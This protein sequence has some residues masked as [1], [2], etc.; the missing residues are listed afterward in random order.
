MK[1]TALITAL[2]FGVAILV[3]CTEKIAPT[4]LHG[5]FLRNDYK[6]ERSGQ[7]VAFENRAA[8]DAILGVAKTM[9]NAIDQPDFDK[10]IVA[11]IFAGPGERETTITV[12]KL[13]RKGKKVILNVTIDQ[14][15]PMSYTSSPILL[16]EFPKPHDINSAEVVVEVKENGA[17]TDVTV[18]ELSWR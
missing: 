6:V 14:K 8:F 1:K 2:I 5:Y 18:S 9:N 17:V 3:A 12:D 15:G 13:V 4:Y 7:V 10:N 16:F 11:G